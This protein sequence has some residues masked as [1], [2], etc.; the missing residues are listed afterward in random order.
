MKVKAA[1]LRNLFAGGWGKG[2]TVVFRL[3]QIPILISYLGVADY[4]RWLILYSFPSW[5]SLANLG[6][7]SVAANE[8]SMAV[9][10]S[11]IKKARGLYATT[12]FLITLILLAG[13]LIIAASAPFIAWEKALKM[14]PQD[15]SQL[16]RAVICFGV[17]TLLSF[18]TELFGARFRA[19]RQAY[20]AVLFGSFHPWM[21][22]AAMIVVF[23]FTTRFDYLAFGLLCSG[24]LYVLLVKWFSGKAMPS[25]RFSYT[26]VNRREIGLL[27]KKGMAFQAFPLGNAFLYQGNLLVVQLLLGPVS[28]ALFGT[29]RTLVRSINQVLELINLAVWP[30]L[31]FLFGL[32]DYKRI[33]RLHRVG[34]SLSVLAAA[35]CVL[36]MATFGQALYSF[37]THQAIPLPKNLLLLF[38]LPI[39]FNSLWFTS[40][41]THMASNKHEGLAV[42]YL[43][44]MF[45]AMVGCIVLS[46]YFGVSGAALSTLIADIVLIPYVFNTSL[47]LTQDTWSG[48]FSGLKED[49]A[50]VPRHIKIFKTNAVG[51]WK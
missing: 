10:A 17:F 7:G 38:L 43:A 33:A 37:W 46:Y 8:I 49:L 4:G 20:R 29:V 12:L 25:L 26:G 50:S 45:L 1:L 11:D 9:A 22:L 31:S 19:A 39:P 36:F 30:E 2:S 3:V 48:F 6:F 18:Y 42:R 23:Q 34:V 35:V 16:S 5:I 32:Q 27:F 44:A 47:Q 21:E 28:V 24:L 13:S 15:H 14:R 41:V 40:S 51:S